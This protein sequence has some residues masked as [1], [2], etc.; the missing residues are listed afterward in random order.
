MQ[1]EGLPH[2]F[3]A[4]IAQTYSIR[5]RGT[6]DAT[7]AARIAPMTVRHEILPDLGPSTV[8]HGEVQDQAALLGVINLLYDLG[9]TL[10][11]V[12]CEP[13]AVWGAV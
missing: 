11:T 8:L 1:G 7:W 2:A 9:F 5:V 3:P 12:D 10:L 13:H 6:L 4:D